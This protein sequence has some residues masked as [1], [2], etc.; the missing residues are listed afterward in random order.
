[1]RTSLIHIFITSGEAKF[2]DYDSPCITHA[3]YDIAVHF[4]TMHSEYKTF[5]NYSIH[6]V[7]FFKCMTA[8]NILS[9][10]IIELRYEVTRYNEFWPKSR[11]NE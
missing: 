8:R 11:Y 2:I 6:F 10:L 3:V 9:V 1:M 7:D 5:A 4:T